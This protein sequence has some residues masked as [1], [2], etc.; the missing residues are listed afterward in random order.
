MFTNE[1]QT[2]LEEYSTKYGNEF[3]LRIESCIA[4]YDAVLKERFYTDNE[5]A[6]GGK[7]LAKRIAEIFPDLRYA[8]IYPSDN[9]ATMDI[10]LDF[11]YAEPNVAINE[12]IE[13][14]RA[15]AIARAIFLTNRFSEHRIK[16]LPVLFTVRERG[17]R[18][19]IDHT[20]ERAWD[21][22]F[23]GLE[24]FSCEK[25]K[26]C[27]FSFCPECGTGV[28][29]WRSVMRDVWGACERCKVAWYVGDCAGPYDPTASRSNLD[30]LRQ[31]KPLNHSLEY[32]IPDLS[33]I[34]AV[35]LVGDAM[36]DAA[37]AKTLI[38]VI[39]K[40]YGRG[41]SV[42]EITKNLSIIDKSTG[43]PLPNRDGQP[44]NVAEL[45]S[46]A[47]DMPSAMFQDELA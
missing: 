46:V 10:L 45:F 31:F 33:N 44:V 1:L 8:E 14:G 16:D 19:G 34:P 9:Y 24:V 18:D 20:G 2:K 30:Y 13:P 3:D 37:S 28:V 17:Y 21:M 15:I 11:G 27:A 47:L 6:R 32:V 26:P 39:A 40:Q 35:W 36:K 38:E 22:E 25:P 5:V 29:A 41:K 7:A 4:S 12:D 43:Q 42:L 23:D